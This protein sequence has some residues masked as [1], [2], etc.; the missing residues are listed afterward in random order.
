[1]LRPLDIELMENSKEIVPF[2]IENFPVC[3]MYVDLNKLYCPWHWH[4]EI[5]FYYVLEGE[6]EY[7]I[8]D[9]M[10]LLRKGD[11]GLVNTN[12]PHM[13]RPKDGVLGSAMKVMLIEPEFL[14]GEYN[15]AIERRYFRPVLKCQEMAMILLLSEDGKTNE[16]IRLLQ[17]AIRQYEKKEVG[18]EMEIRLCLS[19]FW[20]LMYE[21]TRQQWEHAL[22]T[23]SAQA[24][25]A[26]KMLAYIMEHYGERIVLKDIAG[27]ANIS[28]RE[29]CRCFREELHISPMEY[30]R[31]FRI[32]KASQMLLETTD[33]ITEISM[34]CGFGS[35]SYFGQIFRDAAGCTP[36]E[37]RRK[38]KEISG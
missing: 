30:V 9:K 21:Q 15:G 32:K 35:V 18:Y 27:A 29:C 33:S 10:Y 17:E 4:N 28:T 19:R 20:L 13:I 14:T 34:K 6:I 16:C 8:F 31:D 37:Y 26:R 36:Q 38:G 11:V 22:T 23:E 25:R 5:E 1:M 3:M 7:Y 24:E 2:E 12:V